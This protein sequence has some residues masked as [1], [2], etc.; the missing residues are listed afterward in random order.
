MLS[1]TTQL[2]W[3]WVYRRISSSLCTSGIA[4]NGTPTAIFYLAITLLAAHWAELYE[5]PTGASVVIANAS[6]DNFAVMSHSSAK[7]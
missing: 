6:E 2:F 4:P 7:G 1:A 3:V 5:K